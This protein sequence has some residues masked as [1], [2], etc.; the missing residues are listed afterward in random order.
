VQ[1]LGHSSDNEALELLLN[2]YWRPTLSVTGLEGLPPFERAGNVVYKEM[3]VR[4][5][6]R[7]PPTLKADKAT[8]IVREILTQKRD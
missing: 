7:L 3:K 6:L 5:S 2:N 8:E 1:S 4:V